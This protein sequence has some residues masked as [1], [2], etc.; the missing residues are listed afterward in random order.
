MSSLSA[1]SEFSQHFQRSPKFES[2]LGGSYLLYVGGL[3]RTK[4][5][6]TLVRAFAVLRETVSPREITLVVTSVEELFF[7]RRLHPLKSLINKLDLRSSV[8]LL[9]YIPTPAL[10]YLYNGAQALVHV[11]LYEGFGLTPL[12]AIAC[13]TPVVVSCTSSIPEVVGEAGYYV[14]NPMDIGEIVRALKAVVES[15]LVAARDRLGIKPFYHTQVGERL[16]FASELKVIVASGLVPKLVN[17]I[18]IW[19]YLSFRAI[20]N[21]LTIWKGVWALPPV[22]G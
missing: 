3:Q 14:N 15:T 13:G 19:H 12:E 5:V 11:S 7:S 21:P 1:S 6:E 2:H 17:P 18:S 20:P 22:S 10:V 16:V 8:I 9:G 4:N